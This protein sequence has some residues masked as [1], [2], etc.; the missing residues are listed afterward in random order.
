MSRLSTLSAELAASFTDSTEDMR[1]AAVLH[2]C[3]NAVSTCSL[4]GEAIAKALSCIASGSHD[5]ELSN[6]LRKQSVEFDDCYFEATEQDIDLA[7]S[8]FFSKART[9]EALAFA[10]AQVGQLDEA[11]YEALH[12]L[13]ASKNDTAAITTMLEAKG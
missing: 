7:A 13:G 4:D 3:R 1:R 9:T 6:T 11:L 5:D 8:E 2:T 10:T 12:A